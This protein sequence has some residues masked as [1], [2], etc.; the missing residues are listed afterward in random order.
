MKF[1]FKLSHA[2]TIFDFSTLVPRPKFFVR[3]FSL[4]QKVS[5]PP[6]LSTFDLVQGLDRFKLS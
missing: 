3:N 6:L 5:M 2:P 1:E 4:T